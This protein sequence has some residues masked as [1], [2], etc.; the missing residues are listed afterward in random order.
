M[1]LIKKLFCSLIRKSATVAGNQ[2][3]RDSSSKH[4]FFFSV[5]QYKCLKFYDGYFCP[6]DFITFFFELFEK[7]LLNVRSLYFY[8]LIYLFFIGS[9]LNKYLSNG[10][11]LLSVIIIKNQK[12]GPRIYVKS[13][14]INEI[15][16]QIVV[17]IVLLIRIIKSF[18]F[19]T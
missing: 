7:K 18:S 5:Q 11:F 15:K 12:K 4:G 16:L 1:F 14:L 17:N 19:V 2:F 13:T 10:M 3:C 8:I 6:S 9:H